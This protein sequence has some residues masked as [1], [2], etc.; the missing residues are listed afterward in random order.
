MKLYLVFAGI[1]VISCHTN[2]C[3]L[4]SGKELDFGVRKPVILILSSSTDS[5]WMLVYFFILGELPL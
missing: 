5:L 2:A 4:V 3:R 1:F